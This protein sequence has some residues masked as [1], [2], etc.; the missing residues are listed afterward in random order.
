[1]AD[2]KE[3]DDSHDTTIGEFWDETDNQ[4]LSRRSGDVRKVFTFCSYK[5]YSSIHFLTYFLKLI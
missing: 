5:V 4:Q 2:D 1:M 3:C